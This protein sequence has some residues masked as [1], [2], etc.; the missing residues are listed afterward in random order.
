MMELGLLTC[1][2]LLD[3][4][5]APPKYNGDVTIDMFTRTDG[6]ALERTTK[7]EIAKCFSGART[8]AEVLADILFTE[9]V[10]DKAVAHLTVGRKEDPD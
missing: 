6:K 5:V 7:N 10:A 9:E 1:R 2:V 4:L 3:F 8:E